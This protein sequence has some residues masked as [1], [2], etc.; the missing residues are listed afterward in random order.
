MNTNHASDRKRTILYAV[1]FLLVA[2][3][4]LAYVKWVP[5]VDKSI[6]AIT[7]QSIGDSILGDPADAGS[8]SWES[9]WSYTVTYFL[10]VWKAAVLG[11]VLGSLVQVLLPADWLMRTLG[12]TSF[13]STAIGGLT[14]LPGMMCTCCAAPVAAGLRKKNVSIGAALA[15]WL[16]NPVLNPAVLIFMT[17]VLSW[18][19]TLLRAVFGILLV[20]GISYLANRFAPRPAP[21]E[22]ARK[23]EQ[24]ETAMSPEEGSFLSRWLKSM[25][26][27]A[28][29]IIPA[30]FISVLLI[31]AVRPW[32]FPLL[33]GAS[34][35][36][37]LMI[38]LFA[39]G[40]MLFVIP[41]AAEIPII[42]TFMSAGLGT[43]PA[44]ALLITLPAISLPSL[45]LV[46][47]AFP[48]KVLWFVAGAVILLGVL[49]GLVG[50]WIL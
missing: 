3:I 11:I 25:G 15:F 34:G 30:Y 35:N 33:D 27:M 47:G 6:T 1:I 13:G 46:A 24:A 19:F 2:V 18:E 42:Q 14:S 21:E 36:T 12:K 43:G 5:Y 37:L 22:L 31:A 48:R 20:F 41:T 29:F 44:A 4:G 16:G 38:L 26:R 9:T 50:M 28:L 45:I 32:L 39:I 7:T 23:V 8:F 10:A 40:G 17:F 49:C